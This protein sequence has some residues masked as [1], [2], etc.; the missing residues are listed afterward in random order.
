MCVCVCCRSQC[1]EIDTP[2]IL[3]E[4]YTLLSNVVQQ[5][6]S[7]WNLVH[8]QPTD[9]IIDTL[10]LGGGGWNGKTKKDNNLCVFNNNNHERLSFDNGMCVCLDLFLLLLLFDYYLNKKIEHG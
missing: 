3:N 2:P 1:R 8:T 5:Q 6:P 4:Y 7:F 10:F 9:F